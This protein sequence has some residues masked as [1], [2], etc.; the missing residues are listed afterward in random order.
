MRSV[1]RAQYKTKQNNNMEQKI[2]ETY[3]LKCYFMQQQKGVWG[4]YVSQNDG[5]GIG[6]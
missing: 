5:L 3:I 2:I 1:Q 6:V 4:E